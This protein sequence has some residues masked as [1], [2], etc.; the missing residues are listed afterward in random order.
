VSQTGQ[1][2]GPLNQQRKI[3]LRLFVVGRSSR[4]NAMQDLDEWARS[5]EESEFH[6]SNIG[7][8]SIEADAVVIARN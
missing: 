7:T 5:S 6:A 1:V 3:G 2:P 4:G 8:S